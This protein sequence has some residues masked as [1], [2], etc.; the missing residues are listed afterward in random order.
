MNFKF[1]YIAAIAA[2]ALSLDASSASDDA[3]ATHQINP[4][5]EK[6]KQVRSH[7]ERRDSL[8]FVQFND[9]A[10]AEYQGDIAGYPATSL[11]VNKTNATDKGILNVKSSS[12]I[13]YKS[14]LK[15]K[16]Q[17]FAVKAQQVLGRKFAPIHDYQTVLNAVAVELT[18]SEA[19]LLMKQQ[20][21]RAVRKVGM[22]NL[23]T[24]S[25]PEFI[26]AKSVWTG[27]GEYLGTKGEGVIVGIID[28]GINAAHPSFADV[29]GDGY[30]HTNPLGDGVYLGDCQ[31]YAKYCND[32][33]IGIVS[34]PE[35]LDS[36]PNIVNNRIDDIEDKLK[37]G[38]DFNG[39]G[40][41]VASTAAGNIL[42]D[43]S[44]YM[45]VEDDEGEI[46]GKTDFVLESISGVAPHAN[47]VSYQVCN[48]DGCFPELTVKAIEHAIENGVNVINYSVGGS[49]I[50]PW[51]SIDAI[52][53]LNARAAGIHVAIS[54]GNSGPEASTIGS[55][56]NAPWVT[57]V[58]AYTHDQ[59]FTDKVLDGFSG[60]ETTP[61]PITGKGATSAYTGKVVLASDYGDAQCMT[62]FAENTF[63]GEIVV[64]E[65]GTIARVR[66]GLNV[67]AG[68]A[69]GLILINLADGSSTL[70]A[71]THLLPAIHINAEDG[72]T[73][74][75]WLSSGSDHMATIPASTIVKDSSLGDVAGSFTSRG[76]NTPFAN[77][78]SPDIAGPGVEIYAA[79]AE[80][81]PFTLNKE[82]VP[83]ATLS[84]TSMSSPHVA[85]ALAL[86]HSVHPDW[87]PA[88]V[89]SAIM[90]TAHQYT[91]KDDDFDGVRERSDFFDQ[92]AGSIRI[93]QAIKAGLLLDIT[94]DDYMAADPFRG[95]E[96]SELN[97]TSM[98]ND[99]CV[100]T[101]SWTRTVTATKDATW[102]SSVELLNDGFSLS[103]SPQTFTLK[104]G[105]S[106]T[107]TITAEATSTNSIGTWGHGYI[108]LT[109][110]NSTIS[111]SHL[112]ALVNFKAGFIADKVTQE[113]NNVN[114]QVVIEDVFTSGITEIQT[115]GY[116]LFKANNYTGSARG[117]INDS[118]QSDPLANLDNLFVIDTEVEQGT[119]RLIVKLT[120]TT[121]PDMDLFIGI[122]ENRDGI[123]NKLEFNYFLVC[124]SGNVDSNEECMIENPVSGQ[125]WIAA[126]NFEGSVAG[127]PDDV[128]LEVTKINNLSV[129]SF[130]IETPENIETNQVFDLT[131]TINGYVTQAENV[132]ALEANEKYYGLLEIGSAAGSTTD[133]G[134]TLIEL[135]SYENEA[136][137][138][139]PE[140]I[141]SI[142]D[143]DVQLSSSGSAQLSVDISGVFSDPENDNLTYT[144]SGIEGL[145]V[146]DEVISG[147]LTQVGNYNVTVTASDGTN[148]TSVSFTVD[149]SAAP[150]PET[151]KPETPAPTPPSSGGGSLAYFT[152]LLLA[153]VTRRTARFGNL[154]R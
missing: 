96:P 114:N 126:H 70:N 88:Q 115:T 45:S 25:G 41:H 141:G 118:E 62:P 101:C 5:Q 94:K 106:Q 104:A 21:V 153:L 120:D 16:Q 108:N 73:L 83:Y 127:E 51:E 47:I 151:P 102:T 146:T 72:E 27:V 149:V 33:L 54:A 143:V 53:F 84:G 139:A 29:G 117:A 111:N 154:K 103:V 58:A 74:V 30:N 10:V 2:G 20:E 97:S 109:S 59:S 63:S 142:A 28:T 119:K 135:T 42:N 79:M 49:P 68:G 52:A 100:A 137:N 56:G 132:N 32:K 8:Y 136:I 80:D 57:T 124:V 105:E 61:A 131:L 39:H 121:A 144:V 99:Q 66:K 6:I 48:D 78:F 26:G 87:T 107:L 18:E 82:S 152:L 22:H 67:Q 93:H 147:T 1:S 76:P 43:V 17:A 129:S 64:C 128:T 40:T 3:Q 38:Y 123:P 35:I 110:D 13:R 15:S 14:Y 44:Y 37:V 60:G 98:V 89:Q 24:A 81:F 85:G 69:G 71:D 133:I 12:S 91:E 145:S 150:V 77:I 122:D 4:T 90:S 92:G 65:R 34:Y 138:L 7:K 55:P 112:Q 50:D 19:A 148:D 36:Y 134:S 46:A 86:I 31:T 113:I 116:G 140:V 75:D 130:D 125:Y 95:G 11:A 23:H 9:S